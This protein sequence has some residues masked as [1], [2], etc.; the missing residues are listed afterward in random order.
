MKLQPSEIDQVEDIGMLNGHPVKLIRTRGGYHIALGRGINKNQDEALTAGSHSAIVKF[1]LEKQYPAYQ[2]TL[3][4]SEASLNPVNVTK[5]SHFLTEDFKKSGHDIYSVQSGQN[6]EFQ[7]TKY[8]V[9]IGSAN[10]TL[11]DN[12]MTV[13]YDMVVPK[14]FANALAGAT[15]E[16]AMSCGTSN[17]KIQGK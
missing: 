12:S 2:P 15:A 13:K 4:K 9:K 1:N 3:M 10:A 5:H 11:K 16:K 14:E 8:D 6:I 7:I 17:V